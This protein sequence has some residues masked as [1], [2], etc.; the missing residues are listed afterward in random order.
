MKT[1][2]VMLLR[3]L[4]VASFFCLFNKIEGTGKV[5]EFVVPY[6]KI[7]KEFLV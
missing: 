6:S 7:E 4:S 3:L 5:R 1:Y 2:L